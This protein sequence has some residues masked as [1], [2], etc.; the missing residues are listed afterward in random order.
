M[1]VDLGGGHS[2]FKEQRE[3]TGRPGCDIL[4]V[5]AQQVKGAPEGTQARR[6]GA[7]PERRGGEVERSDL[8]F[9]LIGDWPRFF[10]SNSSQSAQST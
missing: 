3:R 9:G 4:C 2:I 1:G 7:E 8:R 6:H 5:L 10:K